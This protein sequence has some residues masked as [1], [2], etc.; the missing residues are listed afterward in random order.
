MTSDASDDD[1]V[2]ALDE[3]APGWVSV[4]GLQCRLR[5]LFA[6][7]APHRAAAAA[8]EQIGVLLEA[9]YAVM[10]ARFG[11]QL[12][13]EEWSRADFALSEHLRE[14]VNAA[15]IA[16]SEADE[17]RCIRLG[18]PTGEVAVTAANLYGDGAE[19]TGSV[20]LVF[21][22]CGRAH[23]YEI[24]VQLESLAGFL[25]LLLSEGP[26]P[27]SAGDRLDL[28]GLDDSGK[29][30]RLL[31]Q[32]VTD[33]SRRYELDQ[34]AVGIVDGHRVRVALIN[35]ELDLRPSNPGVRV[36]QE[37][38]AEC[39]DT[40]KPI[41]LDGA[42][43]EPEFR[44]HG[45]WRDERGS[46]VV[47]SVPLTVDGEV[48][49]IVSM[50]AASDAALPDEAMRSIQAE[51]AGYAA[52]LPMAR[53]AT[54]S[55]PQHARD[56]ARG[57]WRRLGNRRRR[58][59]I[60]A[61]LVAGLFG[62]LAFGTLQY[63]LT[64]PCVVAALDRRIVSCPRD[65]VLSELY[66]R[67]GDQVRRGQLL[68][69]LD[70][71]DDQL[72]K[73]ELE[74]ELTSI[75]ARIDVALGEYDSGKLRV[76]EAQ[77][78][79]IQAKVAV[80]ARR[81]ELAHVRAPRDGVILAGELREKLGA[82]LAMGEDMFELA[83]YDGARV[84]M[85]I[86]ENQI[87]AARDAKSQTFIAA[88]APDTEHPLEGFRLSPASSVQDGR[89]VFVAEAELAGTIE[90]LP[91]GIEGFVVLEVGPRRACWVLSHR[92]LDWLRLNFWL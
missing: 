82:R 45:V 56:A 90:G 59:A 51:F 50:A 18:G 85:R 10:H 34:I 6:N 86:P 3:P 61:A 44:L 75:S 40:G 29:P 22:D 48:I 33:L 42:G 4:S 58:M 23:A 62:W 32:L 76:L 5:E 52:L 60:V 27:R 37:A 30:L 55:L 1:L 73:A 43:R 11:V 87:L 19:Q 69:E 9:D 54:R 79:G 63:R 70:S 74:A 88:A 25:A 2:F 41:R 13:S 77:R 66:A 92:V 17:P 80:V 53:M 49:A 91:P 15:M 24:L 20:G 21:R 83:R 7:K 81:I 64:V 12:L 65:G 71:H 72:T 57:L 47:A 35:N 68:A 89:N 67:P 38:M 39:R 28:A 26:A 31:L 84:E 46:G 36:I 14:Q 8:L 78:E 16:A